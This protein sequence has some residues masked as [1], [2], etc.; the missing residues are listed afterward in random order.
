MSEQTPLYPRAP[1]KSCDTC[2]YYSALKDP[3]ER[4]DGAIIYGYC[5]KAGDHNHSPNMG[6][7]YA[8]F[9]DGGSC[10]QFK[11]R[12]NENDG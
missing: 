9:I 8:V 11:K 3:R 5:F 2:G 4:S 12:R 1:E 10:K 7:G 6:K